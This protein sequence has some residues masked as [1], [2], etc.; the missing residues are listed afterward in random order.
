MA[1]LAFTIPGEPR[2]KG[3]PRI[4]T[5]GGAFPRLHTD[6]KTANYESLV[7]LAAA[8][9]R[10]GAPVLDEP[11]KL[12]VIV[13]LMPPQSASKKARAAMLAGLTLPTRKPDLD[14]VVKC[15]LDGCNAVAFRDDAL[16]VQIA[17]R[18]VYA[19]EAGVDV[20]IKSAI[21]LGQLVAA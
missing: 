1:S 20:L 9:A 21:S 16:V 15:V 18:K 12:T 3:R 13:R 11:L 8:E 17:A 19:E 2:G 4:T 10:R 7:A 6:T 5:R 14:N